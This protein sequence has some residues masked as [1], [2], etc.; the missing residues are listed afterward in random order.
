MALITLVNHNQHGQTIKAKFDPE[1][2]MNL[3]SYSLNDIEIIDQSTIPLFEARSA[4][5]GA[6][7]GPHFHRRNPAI[8]PKIQNEQLFPH[9]AIVKANGVQ[10]PFSHGI[11]RYAPWEAESSATNV[12]AFLDSKKEWNGIPIE[13]LQGF[14][15]KYFFNA[16]LTPNGLNLQLAVTSDYDSLVGIHY[17]YR[18]PN[19]KGTVK[20]NVNNEYRIDGDLQAIPSEWNYTDQRDLCFD[21]D[22]EAD[23]GFTP[24]KDP[25]SSTITL[26]TSQYQLKTTY[27]CD[28]QENSWQ[29]YHPKDSSF[30]CI[31]PMSAQNP[32]KPLLTVSSIDINLEI[33]SPE[34]A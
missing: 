6:L 18:L 28:N 2:G 25:T 21:L 10:D 5:L 30:V 17:Y 26:E 8:L 34:H 14:E 19:G 15:F 13:N 9:I 16:K 27:C 4:G 32:R 11:A 7:I 20:S 33:S 12:T 3:V 31:E 1:K 24:A 22:N 23:F 29:L